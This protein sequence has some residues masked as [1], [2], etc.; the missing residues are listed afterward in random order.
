MALFFHE[1][2][3]VLCFHGPL[4]YEAKVQTDRIFTLVVKAELWEEKPLPE[5]NGPHYFVHYKG[6]KASWD[7]WVPESRVLKWNE[8]NIQKQADLENNAKNTLK[9]KEKLADTG[10]DRGR[11]RARELAGREESFLMRPEIKIQI[12]DSLKVFLV[13]DWEHLVTLPKEQS[14]SKILSDFR[15]FQKQKIMGGGK[16]DD[17]LVE[18][19]EGIQMYFDKALGNTLLYRFERTQYV[20][21]KKKNPDKDMSELYG[22][23]HLLRLFVLMPQFISHTNMDQDT[24]NI[25]K[26]H[27]AEFLT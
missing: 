2:E 7:E 27:F 20:D 11:K 13:N 1:N 19:V 26:D 24:V 18:V 15:D 9:A 17:L 12:P 6:W 5:E 14:V 8:E 10:T 4:V 21:I 23:E 3:K 22:A 25:L 16:L